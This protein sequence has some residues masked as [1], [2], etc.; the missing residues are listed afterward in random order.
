MNEHSAL[1]P[2]NLVGRIE[3][4][5]VFDHHLV[6]SSS[7][8]LNEHQL[9]ELETFSS[10]AAHRVSKEDKRKQEGHSSDTPAQRQ[11]ILGWAERCHGLAGG[12]EELR[13]TLLSRDL[14][15]LIAARQR[16]EGQETPKFSWSC[17]QRKST[18]DRPYLE[19]CIDELSSLV[20]EFAD[21]PLRKLKAKPVS[22]EPVVQGRI[23]TDTHR[24]ILSR[25]SPLG[26]TELLEL[27]V[28]A[29]DSSALLVALQSL[30]IR[31]LRWLQGLSTSLR[32]SSQDNTQAASST[33]VEPLARELELSPLTWK[34]IP[35]SYLAALNEKGESLL[36]YFLPR[37][38]LI[39]GM[40]DAAEKVITPL[41]KEKKQPFGVALNWIFPSYPN[42]DVWRNAA[43]SFGASFFR[44]L[45]GEMLLR[46]DEKIRMLAI[47]QYCDTR[48]A[49]SVNDVA[50]TILD[51]A[52]KQGSSSDTQFNVSNASLA[53]LKLVARPYV[54]GEAREDICA[55]FKRRHTLKRHEVSLENP[56]F[57]T[58]IALHDHEA[59]G[60]LLALT[61]VDEI[62][63]VPWVYE[64]FQRLTLCDWEDDIE[65]LR[66]AWVQSPTRKRDVLCLDALMCE[67]MTLRRFAI[68]ELRARHQLEL[69]YYFFADYEERAAGRAR[70]GDALED[71]SLEVELLKSEEG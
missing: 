43:A 32:P 63:K 54:F 10:R 21:H 50:G 70:W 2:P 3:I 26:R 49:G 69:G 19:E 68:E 38:I 66:N 48:L 31:I 9:E 64:M 23:N 67:N 57:A 60:R 71:L 5:R 16:N 46:P 45:L 17:L 62:Q 6:Y 36:H 8:A 22:E 41:G 59:T 51:I 12:N 40:L 20:F 34:R 13:R 11:C 7:Q 55:S 24:L 65:K 25:E 52:S 44:D 27:N 28:D 47:E 37:E 42:V 58:L 18:L 1:V 35:L 56:I 61:S 29:Q 15:V 53:A 30:L 4:V 33:R 14:E 39:L